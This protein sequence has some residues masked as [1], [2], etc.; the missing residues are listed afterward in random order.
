MSF[1]GWKSNLKK[2]LENRDTEGLLKALD[3]KNEDIRISAAFLLAYLGDIRAE[4]PFINTL[5]N[6]NFSA[7][8]NKFQGMKGWSQ[9][10]AS[11]VVQ[12][13]KKEEEPSVRWNTAVGLFYIGGNAVD[14]L[15]DT[16][17]D[18]DWS[19]RDLAAVTLSKIGVPSIEPLIHAL[20]KDNS[21][22]RLGATIALGEIGDERAVES[23]TLALNDED[24][25][26][27]VA[28]KEALGKI[29]NN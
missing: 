10:I 25:R 17:A 27:R 13:L 2:L 4:K 3:D 5:R 12:H 14:A 18:E 28:S 9:E 8:Q 15:I 29:N 22:I 24:E 26:V 23:L 21:N 6:V 11:S 19:T 16:L 1:F 7:N 20:T